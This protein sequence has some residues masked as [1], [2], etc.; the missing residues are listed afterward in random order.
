MTS[1]RLAILQ[2]SSRLTTVEAPLEAVRG[3]PRLLAGLIQPL[4]PIQ[5][6][7]RDLQRGGSGEDEEGGAFLLDQKLTFDEALALSRA[8][9]TEWCLYGAIEDD[10]GHLA[11]ELALLHAPSGKPALDLRHEGTPGQLASMI[12]RAVE[13]IHRAICPAAELP[14]PEVLVE[15]LSACYPALLHYLAALSSTEMDGR[16]RRLRRA[17]EADP[18]FVDAGLELAQC[19]LLL[20]EFVQAEEVLVRTTSRSRLS[21]G[22]LAR[23]ALRFFTRGF[24]QEAVYLAR[25]TMM[26]APDQA[27]SYLPY[28]KICL[29]TGNV[30]DGIKYTQRAETLAPTHPALQAYLALF[31]RVLQ[32]PA[33]AIAHGRRAVELDPGQAFHHY[34]LGSAHLFSGAIRTAVGHFER[35]LE[36]NPTDIATHRE[37][38]LA[39]C[40]TLPAPEARARID[41]SLGHLPR[42]AFL[43]TL[44][45]RTWM[46]EDKDQARACLEAAIQHQPGFPD[47][48]G[49]LGGL[50]RE[51]GD[52]ARSQEH[53][54][55]AVA[56]DPHNPEWHREL[57][58]LYL[59][60]GEATQAQ[61]AF[62]RAAELEQ[63]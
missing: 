22:K 30:G 52:L 61:A 25:K 23:V 50:L 3:L 35:A 19:H 1:P 13:E 47:A 37:L 44:K 39:N 24:I 10:P 60:R 28:I 2:L 4:G 32:R 31:Y 12:G 11:L 20:R 43:L 26:W 18:E 55:K 5:C 59:A 29:L 34:A 33:E 8:V 48:H 9:D 51:R 14:Q 57:G 27:E 58:K 40:E 42:D 54:E 49:L 38:A 63:G 56:L 45:A 36:L 62:Q 53:M 46:G 17:V 41:R 6:E 21:V 16:I 7:V 15:G